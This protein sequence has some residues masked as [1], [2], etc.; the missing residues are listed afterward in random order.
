MNYQSIAT[1]LPLSMKVRELALQHKAESDGPYLIKLEEHRYLAKRIAETI[2]TYRKEDAP[3]MVLLMLQTRKRYLNEEISRASQKACFQ[4][5]ELA[6]TR[7]MVWDTI[8]AHSQ[9]VPYPGFC[10]KPDVCGGKSSCQQD[11][12]CID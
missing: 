10:V 11:P 9:Q 1:S 2:R 6:F 7:G 3:L 12:N 5:Q 8:R 4:I